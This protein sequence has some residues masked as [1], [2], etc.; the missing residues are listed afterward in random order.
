MITEILILNPLR[1]VAREYFKEEEIPNFDSV[2]G[3]IKIDE[4]AMNFLYYNNDIKSDDV[5]VKFHHLVDGLGLYICGEENTSHNKRKFMLLFPF[6]GNRVEYISSLFKLTVEMSNELQTFL[7]KFRNV[8][9]IMYNIHN[10]LDDI[11]TT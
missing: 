6:S 1:K 8:I 2:S 11:Q 7:N 3:D 9:A 4:E 5:E 10:D